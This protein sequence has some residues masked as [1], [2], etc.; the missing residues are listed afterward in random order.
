MGVILAHI[1]FCKIIREVIKHFRLND[2]KT[3]AY[4]DDFY[5][6]D[7]IQCI[8][9]KKVWALS[10]LAK[11]GWHINFKKSALSPKT[12]RTFIGF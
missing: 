7:D 3:V 5:L 4:V 12:E 1:F 6:C 2:L 11:L 10:E 8:E 9:S